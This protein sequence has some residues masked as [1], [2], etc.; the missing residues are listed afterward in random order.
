MRQWYLAALALAVAGCGTYREEVRGSSEDRLNFEN[1]R[2]LWRTQ[3]EHIY[4]PYIV[5]YAPVREDLY[6][7]RV[8]G[9]VELDEDF[10]FDEEVQEQD[11][12][13]MLNEWPAASRDVGRAMIAKYGPPDGCTS[14]FLYWKDQAPWKWIKVL[15]KGIAHDW[16]MKHEDILEQ[17]IA[18]KASADKFD[19]LAL[20]DGSVIAERTK[21]TLAARC[22]KEEMNFLAINLANDVAT[23]RRSV[24]EARQY[25]EESVAKFKRGEKVEYTQKL[26]FTLPMGDTGDADEPADLQKYEKQEE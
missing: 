13:K 23:D 2:D 9:S 1:R 8:G 12:D 16:P 10:F 6:T 22:D 17:G 18:Y 11:L 20:F 26:Q 15:R 24:A 21:G 4:P 19:D 5:P 7:S 14:D 3:P 25:Y